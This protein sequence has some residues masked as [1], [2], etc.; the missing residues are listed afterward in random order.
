MRCRSLVVLL[1][2]LTGTALFLSDSNT[3][4]AGHEETPSMTPK[5]EVPLDVPVEEIIKFLAPMNKLKIFQEQEVS[6]CSECHNEDL[7]PNPERRDLGEPHDMIPGR[8]I[9]HD[10]ENRWCLDCHSTK[11]GDK[12]KLIN[13]KLL[14]FKEYY[15]LCEQCHK[16]IYREWKMGVHGKRT[17]YWNGVKEYMHCTQCHNPHDPP[18]KPI[19]PMPAPRK[20]KDVRIIATEKGDSEAH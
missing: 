13:G 11:N 12:F 15:R 14:D 9:N 16:R 18:F 8:F 2:V 19:E 10:S 7:P 6:S 17:G 3:A 4:I 1:C 20:P 5:E